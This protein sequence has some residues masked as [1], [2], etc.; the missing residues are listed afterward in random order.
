VN[1]LL[2]VEPHREEYFL[3]AYGNSSGD[4][5]LL[6]FADQGTLVTASKM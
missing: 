5:E 4:K 6:F 3:Y 2:E 1:R